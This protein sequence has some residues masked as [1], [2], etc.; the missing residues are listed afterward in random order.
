MA[1]PVFGTAPVEAQRYPFPSFYGY[2]PSVY[3]PVVR[4]KTNRRRV[5]RSRKKVKAPPAA[6]YP[7]KTQKDPVQIIVSLPDQKATVY[8]GD[9]VLVTSRVSSGKKGHT[10]PSGVFSILQK[11]RFHRSNIYSRAPM[12]FMQRLTWS[13]IALH[14]SNSVPN[15]PASHGCV[16]LPPA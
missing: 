10:T 6:W 16:R 13:G 9:K 1:L 11:N 3:Q 7:D 12:P 14:A 4:R 8:Q 2:G 5:Y 15:Y